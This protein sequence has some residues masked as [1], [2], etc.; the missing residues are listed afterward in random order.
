MHSQEWIDLLPYCP[1]L[2]PQ[3]Q[4]VR[5]GPNGRDTL[6]VNLSVALRVV[7]LDV[8]ELRSLAKGRVVPVEVAKPVV[9]CGVAGADITDIALEMLDVDRLFAVSLRHGLLLE[10]VGR[11]LTS[12]RTSVT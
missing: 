8:V 4:D 3:R 9:G 2:F 12:K 1:T 11:R 10:E 7:P 5:H 6:G